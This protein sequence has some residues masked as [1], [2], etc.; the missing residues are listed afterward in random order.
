MLV[1]ARPDKKLEGT[2]GNGSGS[3]GG[4]WLWKWAKA[5]SSSFFLQS[6][7]PLL[8]ALVHDGAKQWDMA[9]WLTIVGF[10]WPTSNSRLSFLI[11]YPFLVLTLMRQLDV[12]AHKYVG[13]QINFPLTHLKFL[14][15]FLS[16]L[17][18]Y[19]YLG[20]TMTRQLDVFAQQ[21]VRE[22]I[23]FYTQYY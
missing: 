21:Y 19:P 3:F 23:N 7:R 1:P 12:F 2:S 17:I 5:A 18:S 11:W 16:T 14:T 6:F 15:F 10:P 20:L 13:E 8:M 4:G 9:S 22:Q